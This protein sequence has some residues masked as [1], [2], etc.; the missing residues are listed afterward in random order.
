MSGTTSAPIP[1]P[2]PM[3]HYSNIWTAI[4]LTLGGLVIACTA[5]QPVFSGAQMPV[6]SSDWMALAFKCIAALA[7]VFGK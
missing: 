7:M 1:T 2:T 6:T 3:F 5:L 4:P